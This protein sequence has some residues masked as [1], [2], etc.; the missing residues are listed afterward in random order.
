[1]LLQVV[2]LASP[3]RRYPAKFDLMLLDPCTFDPV[4]KLPTC[5]AADNSYGNHQ[6]S[7]IQGLWPLTPAH[8]GRHSRRHTPTR[9][10]HA[11]HATHHLLHTAFLADLFHH[12]LHLLML[13]EQ[14]ID[15]SQL[16]AATAGYAL[17]A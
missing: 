6:S 11:L 7:L 17:F 5:N 10:L 13:L 15:I 14:P 16:R 4:V 2:G 9:K 8:S 12:L 3:A 1:M